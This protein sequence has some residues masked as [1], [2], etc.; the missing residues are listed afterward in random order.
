MPVENTMKNP[1]RI[2][3]LT[4]IASIAMIAVVVLFT[5][6]GFFGYLQYGENVMGSITLNLPK[7][8]L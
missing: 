2:G 5:L 1:R 8:E 3:G 6:M 4:G 7:H